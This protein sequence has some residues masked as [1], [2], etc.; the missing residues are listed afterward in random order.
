MKENLIEYVRSRPDLHTKF[1]KSRN[2][3]HKWERF[4]LF[5]YATE[6]LGMTNQ[7]VADLFGKKNHATVMNGT[8]KYEANWNYRDVNYHTRV[9]RKLFPIPGS[10]KS[11]DA[12]PV[13]VDV[14]WCSL[15]ELMDHPQIYITESS[16]RKL[17]KALDIDKKVVG[18]YGGTISV[19]G[20]TGRRV[21]YNKKQF[22]ERYGMFSKSLP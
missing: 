9:V 22:Y 4:Y 13:E 12:P 11:K 15:L 2:H 17:I 1:Y 19:D 10:H 3:E 21:L 14:E 18:K 7:E 16:M 6:Y 5:Y 8:S 20:Y